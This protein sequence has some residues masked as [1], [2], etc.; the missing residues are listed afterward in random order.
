MAPALDTHPTTTVVDP[1]P[2][3]PSA[4]LVAL[5][6]DGRT[7]ATQRAYRGDLARFATW[8]GA[9]TPAAGLTG[10]LAL[11][12]GEAHRVAI[13]Y[14]AAMAEHLAPATIARRLAA[15]RSVVRLARQVGAITWSLDVAAPKVTPYRD[16]RGPGI[17]AV[18]SMLT[19]LDGAT[20]AGA[21][22]RALIRMMVTTGL[23]RGEV[24]ALDLA[25]LDADRGAVMVTGKGQTSAA[26]IT[27]PAGVLATLTVWIEHRGTDAGP[28]FIA[29]DHAHHGH[30]LT[31]RSVANLT[32]RAAKAA[33]V[34][35]TV[36]P[37]G[38]RHTAITAALDTSGGNVRA[39]ARFSR[40][41]KLD[42]LTTYDDNRTD[43]AGTLA[44]NVDAQLTAARTGG[45]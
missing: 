36:R 41:A 8:A 34:T 29:L 19:A 14:R 26:P 44:A 18:V 35:G 6:L 12:P 17:A 5:W 38:L 33:G 23:R 39:A 22:D 24:V 30:R 11:D 31:G 40:H 2:D 16:T 32:T 21:R 15:L 27:L 37:H 25:D 43:L 7:E 45:V 4:D 28:L 13:T 42:T 9:A 1:R 20:P 3:D 10:F